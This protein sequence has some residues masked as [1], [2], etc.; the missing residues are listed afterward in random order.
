MSFCGLT[1]IWGHCFFFRPVSFFSS[2]FS[3]SAPVNDA[4]DTES[5]SH[6]VSLFFGC[7]FVCL[8]VCLFVFLS[9]FFAKKNGRWR[10]LL[11][12]FLALNRN[13]LNGSPRAVTFFQFAFCFC[14]KENKELLFFPGWVRTSL[15]CF[16]NSNPCC[17]FVCLPNAGIRNQA[18]QRCQG[19]V[20]HCEIPLPPRRTPP[21]SLTGNHCSSITQQ[22]QTDEHDGCTC[23]GAKRIQDLVTTSERQYLNWMPHHKGVWIPV[24]SSRSSVEFCGI[25][26]ETFFSWNLSYT[27]GSEIPFPVLQ[28]IKQLRKNL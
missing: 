23:T 25:L 11:P 7:L 14:S 1:G 19:N 15:A 6:E 2:P 17:L 13:S 5:F 27:E 18:N 16:V 9:F 24:G 3:F 4:K 10:F 28:A 12:V 20:I 22:P 26:S 8:C 21:H